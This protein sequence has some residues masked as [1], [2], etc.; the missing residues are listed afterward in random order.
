MAGLQLDSLV[1]DLM[2]QG[3]A[4]IDQKTLIDGLGGESVLE[5][6][7]LLDVDRLDPR[8][9][10]ELSPSMPFRRR[11]E[12]RLMILDDTAITPRQD[13][14]ADPMI[15]TDLRPAKEALIATCQVLPI[16]LGRLFALGSWGDAVLVAHSMRDLR[17]IC[18]LPWALDPQVDQDGKRR[19]TPLSQKEFEA[20]LMVY[21]KRLEELDEQ[22]ILARLSGVSFERRGDLV[23]VDVLEA[24]GT[25]DQRKS[26]VMEQQLGA[27]DAFSMIPGA[28]S[29]TAAKAPA[30]APANG[31][32]PAAAAAPAAAKPEPKKPEPKPE[33]KGPPISVKEVDGKVV[34]VFPQERFDLDVAAALGKR[35]WDNVV[36]R[37][38]NLS[39]AIRDKIQRDGAAFL[40]PLEF[41]SEVFID[42]KPLTKQQF[43]AGATALDGGAV[44][45]LDVHFPRY[46]EVVLL[47]VPGKG[48]F[49]SSMPGAAALALVKG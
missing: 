4:A 14:Q 31:A 28:P 8:Q 34:I 44:K 12:R 25:W 6:K 22:Q 26:L 42:G 5:A 3:G 2:F 32:K 29:S 27:W 21:E 45:V 16:R 13:P 33:P 10:M 1:T 49:V 46:G 35:D 43:E 7:Q 24:D 39:G 36:R 18:L 20:K 19:A 40:A 38:D 30:P 15:M 23:V 37:S 11:G 48:R 41:L 47:D 17:A 9:E